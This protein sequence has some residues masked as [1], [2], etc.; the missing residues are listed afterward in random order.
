MPEH[1]VPVACW[2][3]GTN[4]TNESGYRRPVGCPWRTRQLRDALADSHGRRA[5]GEDSFL[6]TILFT[7]IARSTEKAAQLGRARWREL[8]DRHEALVRAELE[9]FPRTREL[10]PVGDGILATFDNPTRPRAVPA[11][12]ARS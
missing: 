10:K 7:D 3:L 1:T 4:H 2:R 11:R 12:C 6:T 8:L 5:A 9:R